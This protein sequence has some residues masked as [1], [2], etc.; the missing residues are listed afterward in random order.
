MLKSVPLC[1]VPGVDDIMLTPSAVAVAGDMIPAEYHIA[2]TRKSLRITFD[3]QFIVMSEYVFGEMFRAVLDMLDNRDRALIGDYED[4]DDILHD[5]HVIREK[6]PRKPV[7]ISGKPWA[8]EMLTGERRTPG[9][10]GGKLLFKWNIRP[11]A[12]YGKICLTFDRYP[13]R[14]VIDALKSAN[15]G[16]HGARKCWCKGLTDR[17]HAAALDMH[18]RLLNGAA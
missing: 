14:D 10:R 16:Y 7:D 8:A 9:K 4:R 2:G 5:V 11:D 12:E 18:N 1:H 17:A 15:W 13:G 6:A 3:G